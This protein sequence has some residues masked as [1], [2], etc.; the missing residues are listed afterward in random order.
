MARQQLCGN[1]EHNREGPIPYQKWYYS[2]CFGPDYGAL[3]NALLS[4]VKGQVT[5]TIISD[6]GWDTLQ[7]TIQ[8]GT[9][10]GAEFGEFGQWGT[11]GPNPPRT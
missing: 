8:T 1:D 10:R 2:A 4:A 5:H 11:E 3:T 7:T 6:T 9:A